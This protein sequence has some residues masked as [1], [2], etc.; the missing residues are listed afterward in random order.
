MTYLYTDLVLLLIERSEF[1]L[2]QSN[3]LYSNC[4]DIGGTEDKPKFGTVNYENI[5]LCILPWAH[6]S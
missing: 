4:H 2:W 1:A 5:W 3:E 6:G